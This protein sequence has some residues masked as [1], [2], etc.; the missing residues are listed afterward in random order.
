MAISFK[1][2]LI[3]HGYVLYVENITEPGSSNPIACS[4]SRHRFRLY[5]A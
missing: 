5:S 1:I 3:Q 2:R 4:D